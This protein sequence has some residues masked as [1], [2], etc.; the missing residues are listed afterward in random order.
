MPRKTDLLND[1]LGIPPEEQPPDHYRLLSLTQFESNP[2]TIKEAIQSLKVGLQKKALSGFE[3][4]AKELY[5]IV[6]NA[7]RVLLNEERKGIYD[8]LLAKES[9]IKSFSPPSRSTKRRNPMEPLGGVKSQGQGSGRGKVMLSQKFVVCALTIMF[10]FTAVGL[11]AIV[12]IGNS[13]E[14]LRPNQSNSQASN[15][16]PQ[17]QTENQLSGKK[18]STQKKTPP[19]QSN[20]DRMPPQDPVSLASS[21]RAKD[22]HVSVPEDTQAQLSANDADNQTNANVANSNKGTI[23]DNDAHAANEHAYWEQ[24]KG[25]QASLQGRVQRAH[26]SNSGKTRYLYFSEDRRDAVAFLWTRSVEGDEL[27]MEFLDSLEGKQVLIRGQV[28]LEI[29]SKR[30]GIRLFSESQIQVVE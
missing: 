20:K 11:Y 17:R 19:I 18:K 24:M 22:I 5:E 16:G 30:L 1:W 6:K 10:G 8:R 21:G 28:A 12:Q 25:L 3:T 27:T 26:E 9:K 23:A 13:D 7:K 2:D 15:T 29:G 4:E 14:R